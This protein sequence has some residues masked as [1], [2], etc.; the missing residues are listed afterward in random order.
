MSDFF[1]RFFGRFFG[2]FF[3]PGTEQAEGAIYGTASG[4]ASALATATAI[5][6]LS[7]SVS[8]SST[9]AGLATDGVVAPPVASTG[10]GSTSARIYRPR[11]VHMVPVYGAAHGKST[12]RATIGATTQA[13]GSAQGTCSASG[14]LGFSRLDPFRIDRVRAGVERIRAGVERVRTIKRA[15]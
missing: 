14:V 13:H 15:A 9:C 10:G 3:G 8:C 6:H 12:C 4:V 7:G 2:G 5:G 11:T 1:G